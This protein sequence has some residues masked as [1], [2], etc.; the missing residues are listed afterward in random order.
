[1]VPTTTAAES[2][3]LAGRAGP[4][5]PV[6]GTE[7]AFDVLVLGGGIT[8]LTTALL[9][10]QHGA[11]VGVIEAGRVGTG[12]TGNSTAKVTALQGTMLS[13]I[14]RTRGADVAAA[15]AEHSLAGV[16]MVATLVAEL[17]IDCD[18]R[19]RAA[20]TL[21]LDDSELSAV[22]QETDAARDAGLPVDTTSEVDLPFDVA[23]AVRLDDQ[24]ELHPLAYVR[25]LA[26]R[27]TLMGRASS[28]RPAR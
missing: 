12:A 17:G 8:G 4:S 13:T 24:L 1:M 10:K 19:R 18:L 20:Y 7:R 25:G 21:A 22:E 23:G 3:W 14:T 2:L 9:L 5:F 15:Y 11:K 16:E 6:P 26:Q 27:S 28:S